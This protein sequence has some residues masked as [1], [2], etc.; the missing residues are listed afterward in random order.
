MKTLLSILLVVCL[1]QCSTWQK[2][3]PE[4]QALIEQKAIAAATAAA[5]SAA[6]GVIDGKKAKQ[7]AREAGAAALEAVKTQPEVIT[8]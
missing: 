5:S 4:T 6:Q 8:P 2:L 3:S 7:I 1:C